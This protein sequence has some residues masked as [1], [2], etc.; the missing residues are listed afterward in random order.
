M[1]FRQPNAST[2]FRDLRIDFWPLTICEKIRRLY[3]L[4]PT[5][6]TVECMFPGIPLHISNVA[7]PTTANVVKRPKTIKP[8]GVEAGRGR[9][10]AAA[11][12]NSASG[13]FPPSDKD[14]EG[15]DETVAPMLP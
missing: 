14:P 5:L 1:L 2:L 11:V 9:G 10:A 15:T 4:S 12:V 13:G 6:K 7:A 3:A 8:P